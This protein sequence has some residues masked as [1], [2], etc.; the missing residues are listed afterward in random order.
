M[1]MVGAS[2]LD[3]WGNGKGWVLVN[4]GGMQLSMELVNMKYDVK[5]DCSCVTSYSMKVK[6]LG[7]T[8]GPVSRVLVI[9]GS[10][11]E[12][13]LYGMQVGA[14]PGTPVDLTHTKRISLEFK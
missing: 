3:G 14:G 2:S 11:R 4:A 13:E 6:E 9:T 5:P 8:L 7:I 1:S 10:W 12:L